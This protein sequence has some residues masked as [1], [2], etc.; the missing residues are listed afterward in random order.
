MVKDAGE[1]RLL[2]QEVEE[3]HPKDVRNPV[4][5]GQCGGVGH[6]Y[7]ISLSGYIFLRWYPSPIAIWQGPAAHNSG[8]GWR[9]GRLRDG[10]VISA[11][12]KA[13]TFQ[14]S[15]SCSFQHF[16]CDYLDFETPTPPPLP[17]KL[18]HLSPRRAQGVPP[19][20]SHPERH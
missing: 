14:P 19:A 20:D 16:S 8:E 2:G 5:L 7:S 11:G 15:G 9:Q 10:A 13:P 17:Q 4:T 12:D 6:T 3:S 1:R 18:L